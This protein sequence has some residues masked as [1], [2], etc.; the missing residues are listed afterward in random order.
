M[1]RIRLEAP[2]NQMD[3][4]GNVSILDITITDTGKGISTDYLRTSLYT[5]E[6]CRSTSMRL[7]SG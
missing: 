1:V 7:N 5:R 6:S 3:D 4:R 2:E